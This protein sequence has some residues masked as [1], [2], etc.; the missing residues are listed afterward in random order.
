MVGENDLAWHE[1]DA[2]L[3]RVNSA[4]NAL[5][6]LSGQSQKTQERKDAE[7]ELE[8]ALDAL[9]EAADNITSDDDDDDD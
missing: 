5:K 1:W 9:D 2:A 8:A 4:A 7:E 3:K 6:E